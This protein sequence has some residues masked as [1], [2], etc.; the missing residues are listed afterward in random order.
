MGKNA[1]EEFTTELT[2]GD[3]KNIVIVINAV[4]NK[5]ADLITETDTQTLSKISEK[6]T[7][8]LASINESILIS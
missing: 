3:L 7:K 5:T 8:F 1:S 2:I 4:Q 6:I